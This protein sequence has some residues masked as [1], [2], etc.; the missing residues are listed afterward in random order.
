MTVAQQLRAERTRLN[1]TRAQ[2]SAIL[3]D[4]SES[5]VIK[6]EGGEREPHVWMQAEALRRLR[7]IKTREGHH[8]N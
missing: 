5:W 3:Q 7:A 1:L 4:V 2:T 8:R 6:A